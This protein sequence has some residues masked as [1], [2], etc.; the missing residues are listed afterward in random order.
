MLQ[1]L[2]KLLRR[3]SNIAII[4][5][6]V[7]TVLT[8]VLWYQNA[9]LYST[10]L[11][12][13]PDIS[14]KVHFFFTTYQALFTAFSLFGAFSLLCLGV[15]LGVYLVLFIA[16]L[17]KAHTPRMAVSSLGFFGFIAGL[18]GVGCA[19][20]GVVVFSSLLGFVGGAATLAALPFM[21]EELVVVGVV[22][23]L[24][25]NWYLLKK[26]TDPLVCLVE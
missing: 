17:K 26:L 7:V 13:Q 5:S 15:L 9:S 12:L 19:A 24:I 16:Y 4:V 22:L 3:P 23:L 11:V 2:Y 14:A 8:S 10:G 6:I 20:C 21:G 1:T 18:F 25:S